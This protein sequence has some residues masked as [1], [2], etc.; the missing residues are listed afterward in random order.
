MNPATLA[1]I[2][3]TA[4]VCAALTDAKAG[5][6]LAHPPARTEGMTDLDWRAAC[7]RW[8]RPARRYIC[9]A[10]DKT[11]DT[12]S[13]AKECCEPEIHEVWVDGAGKEY[14]SATELAKAVL[15]GRIRHDAF[16]GVPSGNCPV[17]G[18]DHDSPHEAVECCLWK[19]LAAPARWA[20]AAAIEAG[21]TWADELAKLEGGAA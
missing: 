1:R 14:L 7:R 11:H 6:D 2:R 19:D 9:G 18:R 4:E 12:E 17:C 16:T 21:S 5:T 10:C 3:A 8:A 13:D 20:M 15:G